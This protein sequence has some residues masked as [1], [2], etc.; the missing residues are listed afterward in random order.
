MHELNSL[1]VRNSGIEGID[2]GKFLSQRAFRYHIFRAAQ[3]GFLPA[4]R[5]LF[6]NEDGVSPKIRCL[7][8][9]CPSMPEG[10][11]ST[12]LDAAEVNAAFGI[13]QDAEDYEVQYAEE[14]ERR[15]SEQRAAVK[16]A[17]ERHATDKRIADRMFYL[18]AGAFVLFVAYRLRA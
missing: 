8:K 15:A 2:V 10:T 13:A 5:F 18:I 17:R 12:I 1:V 16:Q 3:R 6:T 9:G 7:P 11:I 14:M 4:I